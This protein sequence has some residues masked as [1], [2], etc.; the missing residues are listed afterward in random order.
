LVEFQA[1]HDIMH[2]L[3][4]AIRPPEAL[5]CQLLGLTGDIAGARWQDDDQ[6][7]LTLRFIGDVDS[8]VAEDISTTLGSI[9]AGPLDIAVDGVGCFARKGR[10]EALWAGVSPKAALSALHR[11]IDRALVRIGQAPER[12]AYM[13]HITLARLGRSAGSVDDFVCRHAGLT[14]MPHRIG[15]FCL[16]ES[17]IGAVGATYTIVERYTLG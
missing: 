3:F 16:Y 6:L 7:H 8:A 10:V 13:P 15:H 9:L 11:K 1:K 14:S 5:R 4:V 17:R 2:R 12:R